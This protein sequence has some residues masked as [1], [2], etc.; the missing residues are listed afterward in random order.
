[1]TAAC[2]V[3]VGLYEGSKSWDLAKAD[4]LPV[5]TVREAATRPTSFM[6]LMPDHTQKSVY[7]ESHRSGTIDRQDADV[8]SRLQHPF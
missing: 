7:E 4:G 1:M 8:R 5:M 3:V 2:D 6:M